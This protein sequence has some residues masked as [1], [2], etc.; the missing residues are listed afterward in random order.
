MPV[1]D[2]VTVTFREA[3]HILSSARVLLDIREKGRSFRYL[4]SG[5]MGRGNDEILRDPAPVENV[6]YLQVE[7]TD[8][9]REHSTK[10][11]ATAETCRLIRAT[12]KHNGK[13]IIPVFAVGRTQQI[14]FVLH[15]LILAG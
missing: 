1:A 13:V 10:S 8:G 11:I 14:V 4:F 5:D 2:G 7:S 9:G 3:G 15:Q 6:D 12:L